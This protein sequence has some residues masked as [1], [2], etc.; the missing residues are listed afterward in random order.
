MFGRGSGPMRYSRMWTLA[1]V[2]VLSGVAV[3]AALAGDDPEVSSSGHAAGS[4]SAVTLRSHGLAIRAKRTD[5]PYEPGP[6]APRLPLE[7]GALV[8]VSLPQSADRVRVSVG[9]FHGDSAAFGPTTHVRTGPDRK[10]WTFRLPEHVP[11]DTN[12]LYV[13]TR[14]DG[15]R[16]AYLA[17]ARKA[18]R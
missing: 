11:A 16:P 17:G 18:C 15:R 4:R 10:G 13:E 8:R 3:S 5:V 9:A 1:G 12:V 7:N 14:G 6:N 2:S